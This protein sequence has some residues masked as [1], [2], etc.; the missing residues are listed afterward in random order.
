MSSFPTF[1]A[2]YARFFRRKFMGAALRVCCLTSLAG[3]LAALLGIH[4]SEAALALAS[5]D[6]T[7]LVAW[8]C[9]PVI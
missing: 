2:C 8:D 7:P 6:A 5:H 4:R 1:S 3:Y 9:V